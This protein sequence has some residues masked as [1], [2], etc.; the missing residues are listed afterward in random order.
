NQGAPTNTTPIYQNIHTVDNGGG[1]IWCF[2]SS[3]KA[4]TDPPEDRVGPTPNIEPIDPATEPDKLRS[5]VARFLT[6]ATF[7]PTEKSITELTDSIVNTHGGDRIAAFS[8][9]IDAQ[10]ALPQTLLADYVLASDM[11]EWWLRGF[12]DPARYPDAPT[13]PVEPANWPSFTTQDISGFDS[14]VP[15]TW[16]IPDADYPISGT[17]NNL[18]RTTLGEPNNH[19][20]RRGQWTLMCY[21]RD[22]LRQRIG[23]ALSEIL[24][25]SEEVTDVRNHHLAAAR[26]VDMLAENADDNYREALEDV[27][28]SPLM[29][30]FLS[31]IGNGSLASTG[32][33][34]DE[35]YARE[36]MQ[37]FSIGLVDLWDDGYLKLDDTTK[38]VS[39]TYTNN[40]IAGNA[41]VMTGL[42]YITNSASDA[43]FGSPNIDTTPPTGWFNYGGGNKYYSS[44]YNYPMAIY[45]SF[46]DTGSKTIAGGK[47]ISNPAG[48][49]GRY[50][51]E[52][53]KDL[54]DVHDYFAGTQNNVVGP[55]SFAAT[56]SSD[57][58]VNHQNPPA[59]ISRRLIQRLVSSNPDPDYLYRVA[60]VW[61][62]TNGDLVEVVRAIL[63][64]P[65]ARNIT[66][67]S[68]DIGYG[69]KKEPLL[70]FI[71]ATRALN[72]RS[73][74]TFDGSVIAGDPRILQ[75]TSGNVTG[76]VAPIAEVDLGYFEYPAGEEAKF[77][78]TLQY[79]ASGQPVTAGGIV[80]SVAPT[81]LAFSY[82]DTSTNA[83]LRQSPL[84]SPGVFNWFLP[85]YQPGGLVASFG[86]LAP[87]F[88]IADENSVIQNINMYWSYSFGA[89]G[90]W[91]QP[92]GGSNGNQNLAGYT[93]KYG[94]G[95]NYYDDHSF[96]DFAT[97]INK[98]NNY[99]TPDPA[100][101]DFLEKQMALIDELD[102]LLSAGLFKQLYPYDPS[103]DGTAT[104]EGGLPHF[105][106]RNPREILIHTLKD[107]YPGLGNP[108]GGS[109]ND[110]DSVRLA[111]YL[112]LTTPEF[113][114]QK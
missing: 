15:S 10:Y 56:W 48:A 11:Q 107:S 12:F 114:T 82:T 94:T 69:K 30:K 51:S 72:A 32:V 25:I 63:L 20:R 16:R 80:Q 105:P 109:Q 5:E 89:A 112:F 85:D 18:G 86:L 29:G 91:A 93:T 100:L 42:G 61:R 62:S 28:Y 71:Q 46:H 75:G 3:G 33:P 50:P 8:A 35:N 67:A 101:D 54:G 2:F 68:S 73:H 57:P 21:A 17:Q 83:Q 43:S 49:N 97:W 65:F 4:S 44:R 37:L 103:D 1:E 24:I 59:F 36:I 84:K 45:D 87:E 111:F 96:I 7:G 110:R 81:R 108:G 98:L 31:T 76:G 40:E 104:T 27:T 70:A 102:S 38:N 53:H 88:Q 90:F 22:Q 106:E 92:F 52:G 77:L 74:I 55:K 95:S 64:D 47:V 66:D 26:W 79:V 6:Q 34:P 14:L 23:F 39:Q 78:G 99:P 58:N 60:Q 9:W 19:S 113:L 13:Q 41:Q